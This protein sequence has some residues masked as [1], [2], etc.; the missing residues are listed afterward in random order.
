MKTLYLLQANIKG[1]GVIGVIEC[2]F[3][4]PTHNKQHF[5]ETDKYKY[6][7]DASFF[8]MFV[9]VPDLCRVILHRE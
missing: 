8:S 5:D 9:D 4:D 6:G 7:H 3:L 1:V 2:N